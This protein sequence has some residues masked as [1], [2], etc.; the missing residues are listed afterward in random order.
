MQTK[1][2]W[3][4]GL[5][6]SIATAY[7]IGRIIY[8][9]IPYNGA[10]SWELD[11]WRNQ[12]EVVLEHDNFFADGV[13]G[14]LEDLDG[15]LDLPEDLYIVNQY[16]MTFDAN[17]KI[18]SIYTFL[19]GQDKNGRTRTFLIDYDESR[20]RDMTVRINGNA[21]TDF[22]EDKR[23]APMLTILENASCE[24]TV[25]AW[26]Q[27]GM[28]DE[29]EI[30]YMGKRSFDSLDGLEYL[31]GDVDGDGITFDDKAMKQMQAGGEIQGFEVSLHIPAAEYV[32]PVRYIME[33][34]YISRETLNQEQE[35]QQTESAKE[36]E[37]WS[38]DNTDGTMYFFLNDDLGWR[39]VVA[40]AAAGSRFYQMEKTENG[41]TSWE[42]ANKDPFGGQIGVTEGLIFFDENFGF[43]GLTGAS[44][45]SSSLYMTRDGGETFTQ[46]QLLKSSFP[47]P[48][49]NRRSHAASV[50]MHAHAVQLLTFSV[51]QEALI[52][53]K[54]FAAD[55]GM[56]DD[57]ILLFFIRPQ[58]H[59]HPV[60]G[61]TLCRPQFRAGNVKPAREGHFSSQRVGNRLLRNHPCL[62]RIQRRN[63]P[64]GLTETSVRRV[65]P[66]FHTDFLNVRTCRA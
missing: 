51:D 60:K 61:R 25:N 29:F 33:P 54:H 5:V 1:F 23:L 7:L 52:T 26:A 39:L 59:L 53:V 13:E 64:A 42:M 57:L 17:G 9:G 30:L 65:H 14:V 19:Y 2:L 12:K 58:D 4:E 63:R 10:L 66:G 20:G 43:A 56:N 27:A 35:Q 49:R 31:P 55:S 40:D 62:R 32:T 22:D 37:T 3:A 47:D 18:K 50:M 15:A 45:S 41:G 21:D 24:E 38:V 11:Q 6:A 46:V 28:G 44:Q 34:V 48:G 16:Q 36:A 8:A